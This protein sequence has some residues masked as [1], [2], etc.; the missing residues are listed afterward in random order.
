MKPIAII[1]ARGGSTRIPRKN[2]V[3]FLGKPLIAWTIELSLKSKLFDRVFVSTEDEEIAKISKSFGA[4]VPFLR[5]KELALTFTPGMPP[6]I[7]FVSELIKTSY[8]PLIVAT[9]L[10]TN[11]LRTIK[12]IA[13]ALERFENS[14]A[15]MLRTVHKVT[16]HSYW[17][18]TLS[19]NGKLNPITKKPMQELFVPSQTLPEQYFVNSVALLSRTSK[20][21]LEDTYGW[22]ANDTIGYEVSVRSGFD[23]DTSFDLSVV[24]LLMQD[25]LKNKEL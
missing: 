7:H 2:I 6:I 12:D 17:Q 21:I 14:N 20:P 13:G 11:P 19:S 5:P 9:L 3:D 8:T 24:K 15:G 23:I 16:E 1:P 18:F 4:E 10:C 22:C 25:M